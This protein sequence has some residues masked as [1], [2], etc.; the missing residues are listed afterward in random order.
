MLAESLI[1][2]FSMAEFRYTSKS[3]FWRRNSE[4][5][6][7]DTLNAETEIVSKGKAEIQLEM[8]QFIF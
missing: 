5:P 8:T 1:A 4:T 7:Y 3:H 6:P 2:G